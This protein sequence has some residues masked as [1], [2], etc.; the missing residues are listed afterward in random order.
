MRLIIDLILLFVLFLIIPQ[1]GETPLHTAA[2]KGNIEVVRLLLE[3]KA[4]INAPLEVSGI[5]AQSKVSRIHVIWLF[6][7][8]YH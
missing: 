3:N 4:N 8:T 6:C 1:N 2:G 5:D 7:E